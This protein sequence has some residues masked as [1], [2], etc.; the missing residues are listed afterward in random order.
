MDSP[1]QA[2]ESIL[3]GDELSECPLRTCCAA[4]SYERRGVGRRL[5]RSGTDGD[6]RGGEFGDTP[7]PVSY[8]FHPW[9]T[10]IA[11]P[12]CPDVYTQMSVC[13]YLGQLMETHVSQLCRY[14]DSIRR[15]TSVDSALVFLSLCISV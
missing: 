3:G 10:C 14:L 13:L 8:T 9:E 4:G 5:S 1:R 11:A 7:E 6:G 12:G 2:D 15:G